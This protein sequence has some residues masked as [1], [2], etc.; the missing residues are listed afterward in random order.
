[1]LSLRSVKS[2]WLD[3]ALVVISTSHT[4][5]WPNLKSD[6]FQWD[7]LCK[8]IRTPIAHKSIKFRQTEEISMERTKRILRIIKHIT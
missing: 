8:L 6:Q 2:K 3:I 7:H 4:G 5:T 1:M